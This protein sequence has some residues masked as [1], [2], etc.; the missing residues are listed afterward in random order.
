MFNVGNKF[1][2]VED[3][4]LRTVFEVGGGCRHFHQAVNLYILWKN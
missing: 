3:K 4:I 1:S 2:N